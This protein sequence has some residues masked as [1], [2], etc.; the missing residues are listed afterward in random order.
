MSVCPLWHV[1]LHTAAC[2]LQC[3]N[4]LHV[5]RSAYNPLSGQLAVVTLLSN[6]CSNRGFL[7]YVLILLPSSARKFCRR[8]V[9]ICAP[10]QSAVSHSRCGRQ[11]RQQEHIQTHMLAP[12]RL[13][14]TNEIGKRCRGDLRQRCHCINLHT[15]ANCVTSHCS[16]GK[17]PSKA[18]Q[19]PATQGKP[20]TP[21]PLHACNLAQS[22]DASTDVTTSQTGPPMSV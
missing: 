3:W 21:L 4:S 10:M 15:S 9:G 11:T 7:N 22:D 17:R 19:V 12:R 16:H 8:R 18:L 20:V 14:H 13:R 1:A 5:L 2:S 6:T